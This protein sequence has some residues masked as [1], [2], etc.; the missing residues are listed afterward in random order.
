ML[1]VPQ[2]LPSILKS[3]TAT[4]RERRLLTLGDADYEANGVNES[5]QSTPND[6]RAGTSR[7][8]ATRRFGPLQETE[9][10]IVRVEDLFAEAFHPS[11]D[12]VRRL[13]KADA[14]ESIFREAAPNF[15]HLHLATHGFFADSTIQCAETAAT[16]DTELPT[17]A[18]SW[19]GMPVGLLSG[20]A[21]SGA[22]YPWRT[23]D[24]DDGILTADE[25]ASLPLENVE[26]VV[27]S[28]C[29]TGLG[30]AAAGEGT[31]G[32]QRAFQVAGAKTTISSLWS[33]SD[34]GTRL[35]MDR[36]YEN[37]WERKQ[38]KLE[39]LREA[40][41]YMLGR[42]RR[43]PDSEHLRAAVVDLPEATIRPLEPNPRG[44]SVDDFNHPFYWAAFTIAGQWE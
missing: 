23:G 24:A 41:L 35:L 43:D 8:F 25:I 32:I 6:K 19:R 12:A 30:R 16:S 37:L 9:R 7:A 34:L 20:L 44:E 39:A 21:L 27:L 11:K 14:S 10:E 17:L 29:E 4:N 36:F 40:Q 2:L 18:R 28:A 26:L 13:T 38:T 33:V 22:N 42:S 5:K 15:T 1:P 3:S 31:L